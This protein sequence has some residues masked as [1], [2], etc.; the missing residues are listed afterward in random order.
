MCI[1]KLFKVVYADIKEYVLKLHQNIYIQKRAV[2][3]WNRYLTKNFINKVGAKQSSF[4]NFVFYQG[5]VMCMLYTDDLILD[6]PHKDEVYQAI[7]D[8][9]DE[10]LNITIEGEI[11]FYW[12]ST[13]IAGNSDQSTSHNLT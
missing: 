6:E 10:K 5:N 9:Q 7:Q 12:G 3:V 11:Q 13:L 8:I 1:P 2:R 4:D